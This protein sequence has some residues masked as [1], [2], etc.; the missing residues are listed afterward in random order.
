[1][2]NEFIIRKGF[3]SLGDSQLTGSLTISQNIIAGGT[4]EANF[5]LGTST[6]ISG[7]FDSVSSSLATRVASQEAFSSSL[8]ATFA[9][10]SQVATAVSSLNAATS[11]Y[12]LNTTDTLD[13]NLIVTGSIVIGT[14]NTGY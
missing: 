12:L 5:A 11:S 7:A 2:A 3:K 9:T 10:D 13:G 1:M 8:D 4:V 6:A 14:T